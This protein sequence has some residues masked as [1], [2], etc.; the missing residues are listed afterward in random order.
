METILILLG[1]LLLGS[2]AVFG[3]FKV[4]KVDVAKDKML[5]DARKEAEAKVKKAHE[6]GREILKESEELAKK[7][8]KESLEQED[9]LL[10]RE[11]SINKRS[12]MLDEKAEVLEKEKDDVKK[13]KKQLEENRLR[14]KTELEKISNLT[15]DEAREKLLKEIEED[16]VSYKAKQIREAEKE[17]K[18]IAQEKAK[19]ILVDTMQSIETDYVSETTTSVIK[20]EDEK[21]KGRIIGKDGRNIRSFEKVTGVDVIVDEAPNAI[22]VSSFDPLRREIAR[23]ALSKLIKDGRI[24]PGSIEDEVRKAK[25]EIA[26]EIT[27]NGMLLAE[28]ADWAGID[29]G[30]LK[31][32]GKM[33]YRSSYGQSLMD[34][35]I[36]LIRIGSSIAN[37]LGA[38]VE[39]VKKASLLH[40][41][42]K[43]LSHKIDQPH[44]NISGQIAKKYNLP[45]KLINAIEAHHLDIEPQSVEAVIVHIAD[46]ISGA[47]PG[48][49]RDTYDA[50]IKRVEAIESVAKEVGG[51][52]L[53]EV[54]A[55]HAGREIRVIV[56]PANTSDD[57][58][59]V[60]AKDIADKIHESQTYPGT[61]Q[62]TVIREKRA[63]EIA[64]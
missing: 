53:D 29:P 36:E 11:K 39:L 42:G 35:T 60:M 3:Y 19:E 50:Y 62:V 64:S 14:L 58:I 44:H 63:I 49:R 24:H 9:L 28:E 52:K 55:I 40:D 31:L 57:E 15:R 18:G 12:R 10:N 6:E 20:L 51:E 13:S 54:Y 5:E 25:N 8:R 33:K 41:V 16:L 30:L 37:S 38:D 27:K 23:L 1:G 7:I 56:K 43:V 48:A 32:I 34:H 26:Q 47:R 2:G 61:I 17:I 59:T 22:G 21:V 45:E 4:R 46:A